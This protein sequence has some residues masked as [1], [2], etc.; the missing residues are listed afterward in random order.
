M[1][2]LRSQLRRKVLTFFYLNRR[3]RVYVRRLAS[4][5]EVDSTNLSRELKRLEKDGLLRSETEG[6]Q[7]YYSLN[8]ASPTVKPLFALLRDSIGV[9]PTVKDALKF[10]PGIDSAWLVGSFAKDEQDAQSDIDV[11]VIGEPDQAW[12][13]QDVR[14]AEK[15]LRRE[16]NYTV[17]TPRELKRKLKAGD[18]YIADL[19][20]GKRVELI[21]HGNHKAAEDQMMHDLSQARLELKDRI[22]RE[23]ESTRRRG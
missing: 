7:V 20:S 18:P 1:L 6:H 5:L 11:L 3:T 2:S 9:E 21:G 17:L 16:I 8:A 15:V 10:V 23:V 13:A 22:E 19:W 4:D 12:L 14:K